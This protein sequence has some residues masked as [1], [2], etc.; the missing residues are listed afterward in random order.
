MP[1]ATPPSGP[2]AAPVGRGAT[3]GRDDAVAALRAVVADAADY[4][5]RHPRAAEVGGWWQQEP[6]V[7]VPARPAMRP[8][9]GRDAAVLMLFCLPAAPDEEPYLLVTQRAAGLSAH[10][11]QV[12][13]PGGALEPEDSGPV[14]AA[15]REA[16]EEVGLDPAG[17]EVLGPLP[18]APV[19]V[20]GFMVIPVLATTA[21]PGPMTP[22]AGEVDRVIR[23]PLS[24]LVDPANRSTSLLHRRGTT[25]RG[26]AFVVD[27]T[28]IWGFTA[29]LVDRML[30][31]LGW[32][33]P[34]DARRTVDPQDFQIIG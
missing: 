26:P 25:F 23:V 16:G 22:E 21:D 1:D 6:A 11:G 15:L 3:P 10:P 8:G 34:W 32:E 30:A 2:D 17:I 7:E 12:A 24:A 13:L 18:P 27:G 4:R 5:S 28:L 29:I 33:R 14:A 20:S 9:E 19:P 31:R